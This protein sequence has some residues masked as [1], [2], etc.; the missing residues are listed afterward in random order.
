MIQCIESLMNQLGIWNAESIR[1]TWDLIKELKGQK[2]IIYVSNSLTEIEQAHDSRILVFHE[3]KNNYGWTPTD[4]L[5]ESTLD[6]HQFQVEF[7]NLS[8]DLYKTL[9]IFQ[10]LFHQIVWIIYFIFMEGR[11]PYSLML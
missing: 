2:S 7:E 10:L 11:E 5:L 3:E 4:K 9:K 8:D 1:Q 6:Y